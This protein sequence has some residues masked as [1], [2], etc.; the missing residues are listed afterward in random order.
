LGATQRRLSF[1]AW[2]A[3]SSPVS[4]EAAA[5]RASGE[6]NA[7][8]ASAAVTRRIDFMAVFAFSDD[9]DGGVRKFRH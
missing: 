3:D 2:P 5:T 7:T 8:A 1:F 4:G 9:Y 6:V